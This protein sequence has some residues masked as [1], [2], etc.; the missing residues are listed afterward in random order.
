M[1][2]PTKIPERSLYLRVF[3]ILIKMADAFFS[4]SWRTLEPDGCAQIASELALS[5][6][7][8]DFRC[9][10]ADGDREPRLAIKERFAGQR[11]DRLAIWPHL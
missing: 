1:P 3:R 4:Y 10:M 9:D 6:S 8:H 11:G 2:P 5:L 7:H